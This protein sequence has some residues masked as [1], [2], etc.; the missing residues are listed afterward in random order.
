[1][2]A[3]TPTDNGNVRHCCSC[4]DTHE[5]GVW[6]GDTCSVT[7]RKERIEALLKGKAF[8]GQRNVLKEALYRLDVA[9]EDVLMHRGFVTEAEDELLKA[10]DERDAFAEVH[11][12]EADLARAKSRAA[13]ACGC[14]S[15]KYPADHRPWD[16]AGWSPP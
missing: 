4:G 10:A 1:M 9:E 3:R 16:H 8:E 6:A 2:S 7:E 13:G 15:T 12:A 5:G 11:K 14:G